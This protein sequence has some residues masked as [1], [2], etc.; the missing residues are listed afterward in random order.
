MKFYGD[1]ISIKSLARILS[2]SEQ[3]VRICI[4]QG[5]IPGI[6]IKMPNASKYTY[7]ITVKNAEEF[8]GRK[9]SE[10]EKKC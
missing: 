8:L 6:A 9:L 4:Q 1:S 5:A 3:F 10:D 2:K 7:L